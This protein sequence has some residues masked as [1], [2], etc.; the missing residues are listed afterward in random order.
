MSH[1]RSFCPFAGR[2]LILRELKGLTDVISVSQTHWHKGIADEETG[3]YPG[4]H[5]ESADECA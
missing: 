3:E 4:W 2:A 5:F 1:S